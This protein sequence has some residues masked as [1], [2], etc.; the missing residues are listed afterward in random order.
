MCDLRLA[1]AIPGDH[2][3]MRIMK[4]KKELRAVS[5]KANNGGAE[6]TMFRS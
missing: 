1:T 2:R 4:K 3:A 6:R 5:Q